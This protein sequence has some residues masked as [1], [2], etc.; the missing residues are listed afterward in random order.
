MPDYPL[1][2][3]VLGTKEEQEEQGHRVPVPALLDCVT[4]DKPLHL[5]GLQVPFLK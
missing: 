3:R 5:S 4:L 1:G 2:I